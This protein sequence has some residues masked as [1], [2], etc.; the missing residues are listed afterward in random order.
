MIGG[1]CGG[2]AG[3]T[4]IDPVLWRAGFIGLAVAGG[5]GILV[6]L[7]LWVVTPADP[8]PADTMPGPVERVAQRL[9][10]ALSDALASVRRD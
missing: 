4:G 5:S 1:V 7:F 8:L 3:Y 2:L 10:G 9:H 6:Y